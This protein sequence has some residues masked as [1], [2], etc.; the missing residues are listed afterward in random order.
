MREGIDPR[1]ALDALLAIDPS[2]SHDDWHAIGRAAIAAG[3]TID[4]LIEWSRPAN[5]FTNERD[6]RSAFRGI[7]PNGRTGPGTLWHAALR[8][9]WRPPQDEEKLRAKPTPR[10]RPPVVAPEEPDPEAQATAAWKRAQAVAWWAEKSLHI[11]PATPAGQYL[12]ASRNSQLPPRGSDLRWVSDLRLFGFSGPALVGRMSLFEDRRQGR[13][14]HCTWL[15]ESGNGW[16]RAQRRYL[17]PKAGCCV[18]LWPD[19]D[20]T[21][22]LGVAEGVE[23]ALSLAHAYTPVWACMDA[24]NLTA[25]P[26]LEGIETLMIAADHDRAGINAAEACAR[27]WAAAGREALVAMPDTPRADL[28]DAAMSA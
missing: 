5:N 21:Q 22:G 23:T 1:H 19:E 12:T 7:T 15:V 4:D 3:L 18:R 8:A 17:G 13:G 26:V 27:R 9:G 10:S 2:C 20:V 16:R 28:N 24:G 14:L 25:M 6:V 11:T